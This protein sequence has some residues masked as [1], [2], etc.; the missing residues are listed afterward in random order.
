MESKAAALIALALLVTGLRNDATW[1]SLFFLDPFL[2]LLKNH[3]GGIIGGRGGGARI[4][5]EV[6]I[7]G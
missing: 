7:N 3:L 2:P 6:R 5:Q 4:S 1:I